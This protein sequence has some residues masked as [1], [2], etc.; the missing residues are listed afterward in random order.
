MTPH[1]VS[2]LYL[3]I[4]AA[5]FLLVGVLAAVVFLRLAGTKRRIPLPN[6]PP[7]V[8]VDRKK[9]RSRRRCRKKVRPD[10]A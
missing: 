8:E 1:E 7:K 5:V 4:P 9:E 6:K 3:Y 10:D 2:P